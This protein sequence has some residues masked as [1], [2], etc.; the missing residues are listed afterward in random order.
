MPANGEFSET[1]V[2]TKPGGSWQR[3]TA[4][5]VLSDPGYHL[6]REQDALVA[7]GGI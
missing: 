3:M 4:G 7:A 5:S 1:A 6:Q 2:A